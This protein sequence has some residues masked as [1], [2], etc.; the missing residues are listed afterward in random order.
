MSSPTPEPEPSRPLERLRRELGVLESYAA[1]IGILVGAGIFRVT[2]TAYAS[3]GA[4]VILGYVV[5]APAILA[6]SV[7]YIVFLSTPLGREPGAEYA[8]IASVFGLGRVAFLG[9]W[10]KLV[11]YAGACAFL[12]VALADYLVELEHELGG[13]LDASA[14]RAPL[15]LASLVLFWGV[16]AWGV[17]WFGRVQ[18]AMCAV[19][20]LAI[21][22]LVVPG[23]FAI[24][25]VNYRPFFAHGAEGFLAA[26]PALFFAYAGFEALAHTAGEVRDSTRTLPRVFVRGITLTTLVFVSMSAVALGVLPAERIVGNPT[27]MA[28]AASVYLPF[29]PAV[30]VTVGAVM[31]VATSLNAS[32]FVPSRLML[33]LVRDGGLPPWLGRVERGTGTPIVG[34]TVTAAAAAA[35]ILSDQIGLAL[36]VSVQAL[37]LLYA[38]HSLALLRL[39]RANPAL[40]AEITSTVPRAWQRAAAVVSL[41]SMSVLVASQLVP[42][43][44]HVAATSLSERWSGHSLTSLELICAWAAVGFVVHALRRK[45]ASDTRSLERSPP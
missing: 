30:L 45:S 22:V 1:L 6:T 8:H 43:A 41:V 2:G 23:L 21:V 20:G 38:L 31:A 35:L 12:A 19:L 5:L 44:R 10:L 3:T 17:R 26:L 36:T 25:S 11:S 32:V 34:L 33:V 16:H 24:H 18:V 7:A 27:P 37:V 4:S 9:A 40:H 14:W 39:P 28:E 15:A 42:D 29:G 13:Q